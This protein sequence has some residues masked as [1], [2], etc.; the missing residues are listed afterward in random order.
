MVE[1]RVESRCDLIVLDTKE[2]EKPIA[3]V[4]LP[5]H[6]KAQIHGNWV[7]AAQV[8]AIVPLVRQIDNFKVSGRG[9]L[10]PMI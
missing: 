7:E 5:F 9:A 6:I 4:Q 10:E 1:R 3:I 2:F 8:K